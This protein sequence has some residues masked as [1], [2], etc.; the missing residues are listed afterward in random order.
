MKLN[1]A[2]Y[3]QFVKSFYGFLVAGFKNVK[4]S[5]LFSNNRFFALNKSNKCICSYAVFLYRR[6]RYRERVSVLL[7]NEAPAT[8]AS[9]HKL[10]RLHI[11]L[12]SGCI[13]NCGRVDWR[14]MV[15]ITTL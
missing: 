11:L 3:S 2:I 1:R 7:A 14:Y 12:S 9:D 4:R 13:N 15:T 8:L 6:Q 5:S 10:V